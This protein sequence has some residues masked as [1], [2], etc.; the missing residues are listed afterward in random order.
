[1]SGEKSDVL[2]IGSKKPV[3]VDGL[4]NSVTLHALDD[5]ADQEFFLNSI[6]GKV[7]AIAC[8]LTVHKVGADLMQRFPRLELVS[9]FGVGYDHVDA[10]WAGAHGIAV[11][12]T[13]EV[14]SEEVADTALGLLLSTVRELPQAERYLRAGKWPERGLSAQR[15]DPAR[16]HRGLGGNGTYRPSHRAA[17]RGVRRAGG[18]SQPQTAAGRE[19]QIL[20]QADR[21]GAR[22]RHAARH[23]ARA[24]P[25]RRT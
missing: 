17:D 10:K 6:S 18:L 8:S 13:P 24:A 12:N 4:R 15:R 9:T 16:P 14:L 11:T 1:M 21:H 7:R 23:R 20:S 5:A 3:I 22:R 2:L 19:V 25:A